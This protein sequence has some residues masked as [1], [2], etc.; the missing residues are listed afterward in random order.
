MAALYGGPPR[1]A[2]E[3]GLASPCHWRRPAANDPTNQGPLYQSAAAVFL[4]G[5]RVSPR[6]IDPTRV[7][8][9]LLLGTR[10]GI[11]PMEPLIS[12]V[13][14]DTA[15]PHALQRLVRAPGFATPV[16]SSAEQLFG[17]GK[18]PQRV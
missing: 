18:R 14:D 11:G 4:V 3:P 2:A 7:T 8:G 1:C 9:V 6:P 10:I 16:F 17:P 12:I 15:V 5:S 13:D